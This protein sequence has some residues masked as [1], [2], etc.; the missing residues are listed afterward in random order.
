MAPVV[1]LP[2]NACWL[3]SWLVVHVL[4]GVWVADLFELL[5]E[6]GDCFSDGGH[7]FLGVVRLLAIT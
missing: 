2:A 5:V 4:G 7:G 6:G 3:G 1:G